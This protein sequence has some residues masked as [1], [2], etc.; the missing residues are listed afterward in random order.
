MKALLNKIESGELPSKKI[1]TAAIFI[2]QKNLTTEFIAQLD[3]QIKEL[4]HYE[5][6]G[7][8]KFTTIQE[9]VEVWQDLFDSL[10]N[11]VIEP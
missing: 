8:I 4:K 10:P 2:G 3:S 1:Y 11:I 7:K 6:E 9:T 5:T